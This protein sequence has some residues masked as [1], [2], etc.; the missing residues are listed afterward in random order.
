MIRRK[1]FTLIELL[2][3]I[4][5]I[6]LLMSILMPALSRVKKQ[7][8]A[9]GCQANLR[10]WNI[11]F[12]MYVEENNGKFPSGT[13]D[14]GYWWVR[15]I[16]QKTINWKENPIWFCPMATKPLQDE[17]GNRVGAQ[18]TFSAWGIFNAGDAYF[19]P[20]GIAGSYGLNGYVLSTLPGVSFENGRTTTDNWRTPLVQGANNVP[21]FTD[22]LRF[23]LW[24]IVTDSPP[25]TEDLAWSAN[26]MARCCINRHDGFINAA[27]CDFSLRK[28]GIKE[29]WTLK[30]HKRF[31]INGPWTTAGGASGSD[32]PS[33][34]QRFKE[35]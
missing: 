12:S 23:D 9:V 18:N 14:Q 11:I 22:A 3:V 24:P 31:N 13:T 29:L 17:R 33:W 25:Q 2:V 10:Q 34:M 26:H 6:A 35:Y 5:I 21:L 8:R 15:Q 30:W 32:W 28:V 4:A 27:F 7:A 16:P 1:G 20:Q 19:G